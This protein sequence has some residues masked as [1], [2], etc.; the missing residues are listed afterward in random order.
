LVGGHRPSCCLAIR[1]VLPEAAW[2]SRYVHILRN[3]LDYVPRKFD[4]DCLQELRWFYDRRDLAEVRRD[5]AHWLGKWQAKYPRLYNWVENNIEETL[6]Y[7]RLPLLHHKQMKS[8]NMLERLNQELKRRTYVVRVFHNAE[9]YLRA[10]AGVGQ[11]KQHIGF[12]LVL[13]DV[14]EIIEDQEVEFVQLGNGGFEGEFAAGDLQSLNQI[15]GAG[16]QHSPAVFD[17][18]E[19]QS[20]RKVALAP[21]RRPEQ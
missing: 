9:S 15:C 21:A 3:A 18:N 6:T 7:H 8:T 17:K 20:C 2:Q 11:F 1:E 14:G 13:G 19:A 10:S 4:D 5:I 12:G 16:E